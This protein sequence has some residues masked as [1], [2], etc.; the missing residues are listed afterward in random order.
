MNNILKVNQKYLKGVLMIATLWLA[1]VALVVNW[2]G[3]SNLSPQV[4][5]YFFGEPV[6]PIISQMINYS[7]TFARAIANMLAAMI[8]IKLGVK[9]SSLLALTMLAFC[10]LAI[11]M[12]NYWFYTLARMIMGLGGSMLVIYINTLIYHYIP[13][14]QQI[15][16]NGF[17]TASYNV[18]ALLVAICF[19]LWGNWLI[20]DWQ[21]SLFI[22]G[23]STLVL[24]FLWLL[25]AENFKFTEKEGV[26]EDKSAT[27][28][29]VIKTKFM[30]QYI[31]VFSGFIFLYVFS[32][33]SLPILLQINFSVKS[34]LII[35]ALAGGGLAGNIAGIFLGRL[36]IA[37][38]K[39]LY[40]CGFFMIIFMALVFLNLPNSNFL[41][42]YIFATLSGFFMC[43][44]YPV[45][46]NI[47]YEQK[48]MSAKKISIVIGYMWGFSYGFYTI[49]SI[50]WSFVAQHL[51]L[52]IALIFY[53][54]TSAVLYSIVYFLPE[55][56]IKDHKNYGL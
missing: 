49:L 27:Y 41:L 44:Q 23:I 22:F 3:G 21:K 13:K 56:Y 35:F 11:I 47:A 53:I 54:T 45:F 6:D 19:S 33:T 52:D 37:R 15:I 29:S 32:L 14:K 31:S 55:T 5:D 34:Y 4:I 51:G 36:S 18:G 39:I 20:L 26:V 10:L 16:F 2:I 48:S 30:W 17:N 7:I 25:I 38:K 8:L 1:Y 46:V 24:L 12:P 42:I 9:F 50:I 43:L 28:L 40:I